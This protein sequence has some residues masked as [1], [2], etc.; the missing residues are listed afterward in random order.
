M[1][2]NVAFITRMFEIID[3]ADFDRLGE[4]FDAQVVYERPGYSPISGLAQLDDFYRFRR[5]IRTGRHHLHRLVFDSEAGV[6]I[7]LFTGEL[8]D[9]SAT[10]EPFA[11]AYRFSGGRIAHRQTFFFRPAI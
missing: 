7:G 5:V 2:P 11:D 4:V 1:S 9:G 6:A 8:K 10:E 3:A